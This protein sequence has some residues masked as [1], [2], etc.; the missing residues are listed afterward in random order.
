VLAE[1]E[2]AH[3]RHEAFAALSSHGGTLRSRVSTLWRMTIM[4]RAFSRNSITSPLRTW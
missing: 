2:I 1:R 4:P 3:G